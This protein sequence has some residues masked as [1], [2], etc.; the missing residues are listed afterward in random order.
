[1]KVFKHINARSLQEVTE[2][3]A[4]KKGKARIIAGGTDLLSTLKGE[5]HESY[6]DLIINVKTIPNLDYIKEQEGIIRIGTLA[7]LKTIAD[8]DLLRG[9]C[10]V[11]SDAAHAVASPQIR[12]MGTIG[13][14][15][16]Q[17]VRCSY[18]RSSPFI[19]E[20]FDCLRKGGYQCFAIKGN[21]RYHAIMKTEGCYAS[22]PSDIAVALAALDAHVVVTGLLGSGIVP[23]T[24]FYTGFGNVLRTDEIVTEIQVTPP[25]MD[26]KQTFLKFRQRKAID[27]AIASVAT[28]VN[29]G[30][31]RIALGAVAPMPVRAKEA[32]ELLKGKKI[33]TDLAEKAGELAVSGANP[34]T[35]NGYKVPIIRALVQRA[36]LSP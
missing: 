36:L 15:I 29:N 7:K 1:M 16:C 17:E 6:P 13:G 25:G 2:L 26:S 5:I 10:M 32:E 4:E 31:V 14:N 21:N 23:V 3:L 11:L 8:S 22:F 33:N 19:G 9:K 35:R 30:K 34:L 20:R 18:Y 28:V 24:E 12:S 27:F